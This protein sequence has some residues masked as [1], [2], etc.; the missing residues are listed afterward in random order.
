MATFLRA[1][2]FS[3]RRWLTTTTDNSTIDLCKKYTLF[4]WSV[5][6]KIHPIH[7]K[8]A[9]GIYFWDE[10]GKKYTDLCS[11]LVCSNIGHGH[12]RM[13]DAIKKQA[14]K[15][16][17]AAPSMATDV[18]AEMGELLSRYTPKGLNK[19]VFTTSGAETNEIAVR[20]AR[21]YTERWKI[22][23]RY[24]S[25]HGG[26][27]LTGQL[28]GEPR[29]W[30]SEPGVGFLKMFDP[31]KYRSHLYAD[32]D[33]DE[34]FSDKCIKQLDEMLMYENPESVAAIFLETITGT[35]GIIIPP[36]GF[37]KGIRKL[38]NKYG[39]LMV[40]DEV[41]CGMGRTGKWFAVDHWDV[42]PDILTMAKG[43]T[44]AYLPLGA[45]AI[46]SKIADYY[47]TNAFK[48]GSTYQNHSLCL[49]AGVENLK[50]MEDEQ[51]VENAQKM[52][53]IMNR[54]LQMLKDKH[55]SV[56]D[57]RS[58][59]LF[60]CIELVKNRETKEPMAGYNQTSEPMKQLNTF[61]RNNGIYTMI[62]WNLVHT[63]PPLC[64]NEKQIDDAFAI[65]DE[66]LNITDKYCVSHLK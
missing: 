24:R 40:C 50:I 20:I 63:N 47:E 66:A 28:T 54:H 60:G 61:L 8:R 31:Y 13:I 5:Q 9:K 58:I 16:S 37:L 19:F 56:G 7:M 44:S 29:R 17:Y 57:V 12:P 39:I 52:G 32:D 48:V 21:T 43:I 33:T 53:K 55:P 41:M 36:N 22:V 46:N 3:Q 34:M 18:R 30:D 49:A 26:T 10:Q 14:E 6:N 35:N 11:Q 42:V 62:H 25:Y 38:C 4:S 65:L 1:A 27:Y 2:I 45:V 15:F 59:G 51:L 64:I 23:S